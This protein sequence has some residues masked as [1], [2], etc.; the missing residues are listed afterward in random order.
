MRTCLLGLCVLMVACGRTEVERRALNM[1]RVGAP[2]PR[3]ALPAQDGS[4]VDLGELR[5][6]RVVL[7][8]YPKDRTPGCSVEAAAFRDRM[9]TIDSLGAIVLGVSVDDVDSHRQFCQ[10]LGLNFTLLSDTAGSVCRAYGALDA[11]GRALRATFVID[12]QGNVRAVFPMVAVQGHVDEVLRVL[13]A[14]P[15][16]RPRQ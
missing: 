8:F 6:R 7:Y 11:E 5:G 16:L 4:V 1:P 2:A 9:A 3:F 10:E 15:P 13:R 14:M 12:E